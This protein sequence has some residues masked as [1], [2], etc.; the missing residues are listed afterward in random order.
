MKSKTLILIISIPFFVLSLLTV[1]FYIYNF[2]ENGVSNDPE[3]WAQFGDYFGGILNPLISILNL[4]IL[5]Y[6]SIKLVRDEDDR[7]KWTLQELARPY[8]EIGFNRNKSGIE[9][10]IHNIGLGPMIMTEI[11]IKNSEGKIYDNFSDIVA[12]KDNSVHVEIDSFKIKNHSAIGKDREINLLTLKGNG[13][14][15]IYFQFLSNTIEVLEKYIIEIKYNDIYNKEIAILSEE[16][17]FNVS[18]LK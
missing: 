3:N 10:L 18:S 1:I 4:I 15:P 14:D 11:N 5:S 7:N 16:I 12:P 6:L 17:D 9:I 2:K 13:D 8:G